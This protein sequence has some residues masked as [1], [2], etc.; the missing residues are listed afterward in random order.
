MSNERIFAVEGLSR[1]YGSGRHAVPALTDVNLVVRRGE[2]LGVVGESGS[3]KSTLVRLL[4][5]LDTPTA[6][7]VT[8]EGQRVT[9]R[10]ERELGFLRRRVQMVF[11]DPRGSLDPRMKARRIITESLRS[12]LLRS[13][14]AGLDPT[15]RARELMEAVGLDPADADRYPHEFSGGQRQRIAID[16]PV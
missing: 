16:L 1:T 10:P 11:Q 13:E 14:L 2:R 4:A 9:G 5:A 6:G 8:F 7:T 15:A 3:G 12:P